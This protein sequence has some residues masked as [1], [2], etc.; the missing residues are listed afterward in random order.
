[1]TSEERV[2]LMD[3]AERSLLSIARGDHVYNPD[4]YDA[5]SIKYA[6]GTLSTVYQDICKELPGK[7]DLTNIVEAV[8]RRYYNKYHGEI[9]KLICRDWPV[10]DDEYDE[11]DELR[12]Y[13]ERKMGIKKELIEDPFIVEANMV[14]EAVEVYRNDRKLFTMILKYIDKHCEFAGLE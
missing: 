14:H 1:M 8:H 3:W 2:K 12:K 5:K 6:V 10:D 9:K 7:M 13:Y 4:R 11:D